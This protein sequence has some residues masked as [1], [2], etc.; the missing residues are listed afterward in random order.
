MIAV[1]PPVKKKIFDFISG[2][3]A[4]IQFD[5]YVN[6]SNEYGISASMCCS[7]LSISYINSLI[8][9]SFKLYIYFTAL[10]AGT[11]K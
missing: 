4:C 6:S 1:L 5:T 11:N 3:L 7:S 8:T 9:S 10:I 2:V